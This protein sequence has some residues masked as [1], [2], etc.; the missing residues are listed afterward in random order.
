MV[1]HAYWNIT[2]NND[3]IE[4]VWPENVAVFVY[5]STHYVETV[6]FLFFWVI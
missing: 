3:F 1:I 6:Y 5:V 4:K 2:E